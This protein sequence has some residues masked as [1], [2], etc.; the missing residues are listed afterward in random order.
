MVS[1]GAAHDKLAH[2]E[3]SENNEV[4]FT[5]PFAQRFVERL[6]TSFDTACGAR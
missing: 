1:F 5:Y 3:R 4:K 6:L 2:H